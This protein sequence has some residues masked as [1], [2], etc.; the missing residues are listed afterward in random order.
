[1]ASTIFSIKI[2][3]KYICNICSMFF[4]Y[5]WKKS[6]TFPT[7]HLQLFSKNYTLRTTTTISVKL[8]KVFAFL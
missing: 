3:H 8:P 2:Y 7:F 5:F 1:M 6:T 4:N